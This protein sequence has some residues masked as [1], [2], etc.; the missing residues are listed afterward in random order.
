MA[1]IQYVVGVVVL[2]LFAIS[3]I[4]Q[5]PEFQNCS[6]GTEAALTNAAADL[7][8]ALQRIDTLHS[9]IENE[10]I[11]SR[12]SRQVAAQPS[13]TPSPSPLPSYQ[14]SHSPQ[15][16]VSPL[17]TLVLYVTTAD[18]P[19]STIRRDNLQFFIRQALLPMDESVHIVVIVQGLWPEVR[20]LLQNAEKWTQANGVNNF[21]TIWHV[22][23]GFDFGAW[24]LALNGSL[25][26]GNGRKPLDFG[27]FILLN[28]SAKGPFLPSYWSSSFPSWPSIFTG[29]L[30]GNNRLVGTSV[31]CE[32][33]PDVLHLQ[34]MTLAFGAQDLS[35]A[36]NSM[37]WSPIDKVIGSIGNEYT[38]TQAFLKAGANIAALQLAFQGYNFLSRDS[39]RF[40]ASEGLGSEDRFYPPGVYMGGPGGVTFNPL[41]LVFFKANR[42]V[43]QS[44]VDK[45]SHWQ[46]LS[47]PSVIPEEVLNKQAEGPEPEL[48]N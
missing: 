3:P 47:R 4:F 43:M 39:T 45:Y 25:P 29:L 6:K 11:T 10:V 19:P 23:E 36:V 16:S 13:N 14:S 5:V 27:F 38:F 20:G 1:L 7:R 24:K 15:P 48:V 17:P 41:E 37:A 46:L 22:N 40:C 34:S 44:Y 35:L 33:S 31:N 8:S 2:I 9:L 26:L 21:H 18:T 30:V 42:N 28:G 32:K 12:E